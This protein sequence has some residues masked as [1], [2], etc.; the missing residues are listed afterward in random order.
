M[1]Q[2]ATDNTTAMYY[3][4]KQGGTHSP[5]LLYLA[6]NLWEWCLQ[7]H[8]CLTVLYI[9]GQDHNL[10]DSL[11]HTDAQAHKWEVDQSVFRQLCR[12]WGTLT[13]D[14]FAS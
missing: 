14:L 11:G 3:I 12:K 13:L 10:A 1:V 8:I 9:A 4:L 2:I 5:G 7:H 6:V